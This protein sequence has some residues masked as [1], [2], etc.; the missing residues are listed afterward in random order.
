MSPTKKIDSIQEYRVVLGSIYS[1]DPQIH[2]PVR[3]SKHVL[4]MLGP[5]GIIIMH[6]RRPYF[7]EHL[8]L[9][10]KGIADKE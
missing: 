4:S 8:E 1:H 2:N 3:N 9:I 7:A 10:L 5:S 6:D